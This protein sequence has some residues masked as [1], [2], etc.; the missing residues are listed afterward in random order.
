M[1]QVLKHLE[2]EIEQLSPRRRFFVGSRSVP[3][4]LVA[5]VDS[6]EV[7]KGYLEEWISLESPCEMAVTWSCKLCMQRNSMDSEQCVTCKRPADWKP[8]AREMEVYRREVAQAPQAPPQDVRA[9]AVAIL[10]QILMTMLCPVRFLRMD[11]Q[12]RVQHLTTVTVVNGPLIEL[13]RAWV[14][15]QVRGWCGSTPSRPIAS[16]RPSPWECWTMP[17]GR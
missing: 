11:E 7:S 17:P 16:Q 6:K 12:L 2:Q 1:F 15:E 13:R 10:L 4:W 9:S 3:F 5:Q 8:R 14:D